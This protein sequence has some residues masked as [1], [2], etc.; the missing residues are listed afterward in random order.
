MI[1][2]K[3]PNELL[4]QSYVEFLK[5]I[6]AEGKRPNQ[7]Q[8][9]EEVRQIA[10]DPEEFLI[11]EKKPEIVVASESYKLKLWVV[12]ENE[13]IGYVIIRPKLD[14]EHKYPSNIGYCIKP[15]AR[16]KGH[17]TEACHLA[18][19]YARENF[20][21]EKVWISCNQ[22]NTASRRVTEKNGGIPSDSYTT[23]NGDVKLRFW[24]DTIGK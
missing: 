17:A 8:L 4:L 9:E 15:N 6:I 10:Q 24:I 21:L 19:I 5:D 14:P 11:Q 3:L 23:P 2:L 16:G 22:E 7:T 12:L 13:V 20:G 18:I 1:E